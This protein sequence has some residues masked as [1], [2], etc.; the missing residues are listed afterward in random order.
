MD[1]VPCVQ[2]DSLRVPGKIDNPEILMI[3]SILKSKNIPVIS[4]AQQF[5]DISNNEQIALTGAQN[6]RVGVG[7]FN[8]NG[9]KVIAGILSEYLCKFFALKNKKRL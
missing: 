5:Y 1:Q 8:E 3:H 4:I 7:H 9:H 6:K 2:G